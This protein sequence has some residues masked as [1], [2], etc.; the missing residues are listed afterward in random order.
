MK[1]NNLFLFFILL[2]AG[3]SLAVN[4]Y[5]GKGDRVGN[6]GGAWACFNRPGTTEL[7]AIRWIQLV[8][9]YEAENEFQLPVIEKNELSPYEL[10]CELISS[11]LY[12]VSV[13]FGARVN[14]EL[15]RIPELLVPTD[16]ELTTIADQGWRIKPPAESCAEG[17]VKFVQVANYTQYGKILYR[18]GLFTHPQFSNTDR[19]GL[20][21]HEA[22]YSVLR[23]PGSDDQ[24]S[25]RTRKIVGLLLAPIADAVA[26]E[27]I[28]AILLTTPAVL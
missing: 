5:A 27:R 2:S 18:T 26:V 20:L 15:S 19:A 28:R 23:R 9:R 4:A 10:A 11:R 13:R 7:S 25:D 14:E 12:Q 3:A 22:I 16:S 21:M 1:K 6:G 24:D 17:V 8:D